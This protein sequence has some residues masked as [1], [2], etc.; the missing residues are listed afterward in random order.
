M[1]GF[2]V[3]AMRNL[4][5]HPTRFA[6]DDE[7]PKFWPP[8]P[9]RLFSL[10][11]RP[12]EHIYARRHWRLVDVQIEGLEDAYKHIGPQDGVLIAPNHSF[13]GDAYVLRKCARRVRRMFY[14]MAAW[15][16]FRSK[17]GLHA[18]LLQRLGVFSVDR[19][20]SDRRAIKVAIGLLASGENLV[21]FPEG[22]IHHLNERLMPLLDGVAFM[23]LAA[24]RQLGEANGD[25]RVWIVPAGIRYHFVEDIRQQLEAAMTRLEKRMF[26]AR[27]PRGASLRERIVYFGEML[28]TIKEKEKLG[29]SCEKDGDLPTRIGHFI[30]ALLS[31]QE[32]AHLQKS[33]SAETVPLRVKALRRKLLDLSTSEESD[34]DVRQ[35]AR[36][37]LDDVQLALQLYSYPGN[38]ISDDNAVE[39]MAETIEKFEEDVFSFHKPIGRR[40]AKIRFGEPID[41]RQAANSGRKREV[42]ND[43]TEQ[44]EEA[45]GRLIGEAK[46]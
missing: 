12:L 6:I 11:I 27:P 5:D 20:G 22:E 40:R 2:Q 21:V 45:I 17:L 23:A 33:P 37:A 41:M 36:D 29:H 15:Q 38:Y 13:E 43:V 35:Q 4:P 25:A 10:A 42:V 18:R 34:S 24:Q 14:F 3:P 26:F 31:R 16:A 32:K 46:G 1:T 9:S 8:R 30:E 28:L 19:E 44:L 7:M 39:R